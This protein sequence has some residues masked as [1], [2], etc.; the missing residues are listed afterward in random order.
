M[1]DT[2][3]VDI[4]VLAGA[5][6]RRLCCAAVSRRGGADPEFGFVPPPHTGRPLCPIR[7]AQWAFMANEDS[8]P[9]GLYGRNAGDE[10]CPG[11]CY[12]V[13]YPQAGDLNSFSRW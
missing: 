9:M 3:C 12:S 1:A 8:C 10:R 7:F 5:E 11:V 2:E 13:D 4:D 6:F